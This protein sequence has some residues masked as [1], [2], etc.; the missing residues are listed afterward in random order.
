MALFRPLI[1]CYHAISDA[2]NDPLA[3]RV[4]DFD[5]HLRTLRRRYRGASAADVVQRPGDSRLLHVTFD[6]GFKSVESALPILE[7]LGVPATVFICSNYADS[8]GLLLIPELAEHRAAQRAE[9]ATLDWASM[10]ALTES[11]I[12]EIGSHSASHAHL[13]TLGDVEL[14]HELRVSKQAIEDNLGRRCDFI[15]YPYGE[16]DARV[17]GAVARAGYTAGFAAPGRSI[18]FDVLQVPRAGLWRDESERRFRAKTHLLGR[19]LHERGLTPT[20]RSSG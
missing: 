8:G 3:T 7:R 10:G 17:R 9:L 18:G 6:D 20:A 19:L 16:H 13:A 14:E 5:R 12:V 11:G 1:L 4:A 2:W 15:A